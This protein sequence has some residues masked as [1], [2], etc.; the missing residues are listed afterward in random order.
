M[1]RLEHLSEHQQR[2]FSTA[3]VLPLANRAI[4]PSLSRR[5]TRVKIV[6]QA[7]TQPDNIATLPL[8]TVT[9]VRPVG[10]I[11]RNA[12]GVP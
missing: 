7:Q 5:G 11:A 1:I 6:V 4:L 9:F 3:T 8:L 10:P 12:V 2:A